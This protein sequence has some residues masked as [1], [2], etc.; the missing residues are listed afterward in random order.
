MDVFVQS[1]LDHLKVEKGLSKNTLASYGTDLNAFLKYL[2]WKGMQAP[3]QITSAHILEHIVSLSKEGL[4]P[5]SMARHLITIRRF[6]KFLNQE[7][8]LD[9]DPT[10][11]IDIPKIGRKLPNFLTLNEVDKILEAAVTQTKVVT[12]E[13]QRNHAMIELLYATGLRVS[14]LVNLKVDDLNLQKGFLKAYG[15]GSKERIVPM[16]KVAN[17]AL[18]QYISEARESLRKKHSTQYLFLTRR[19][20]SMTRQMFWTIIKT[21]A[22]KAGIRRA[23]SP[24]VLR[25]SFA[26]HLVERGADLRSVQVMLGHSNIATTEI[27]THLNL[28]H[29]KGIISKHPRG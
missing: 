26:T 27:Y 1:F 9:Q 12:L 3:S 7:K 17:A 14:E 25:H 8:I 15:K 11:L 13:N 24:H 10:A 28:K 20:T 18:S 5:R 23:I 19:G 21:L 2:E 22:L 16:G 4:K 6:F 29:L